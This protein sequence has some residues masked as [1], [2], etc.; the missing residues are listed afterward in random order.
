MSTFCVR[1]SG[2]GAAG[3][4]AVERAEPHYVGAVVHVNS[5]GRVVVKV[6]R[7]TIRQEVRCYQLIKRAVLQRN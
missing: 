3:V 2:V 4:V 5:G 7:R 1:Y 6:P